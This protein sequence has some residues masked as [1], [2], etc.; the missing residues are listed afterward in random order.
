MQIQE[1]KGIA[2]IL[3]RMDECE[4]INAKIK[5]LHKKGEIDQLA[6]LALE[7]INDTH[8]Y[9]EKLIHSIEIKIPQVK[10]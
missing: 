5:D 3:A 1:A 2:R 6:N 10:F 8:S 4:K 7:I 9:N